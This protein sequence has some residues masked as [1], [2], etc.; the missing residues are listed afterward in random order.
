ML[1][2][3]DLDDTLVT[4]DSKIP[5]EICDAIILARQ[6][7][8]RIAVLTGRTEASAKQFLNLLN[9]NA[10]YSTSHG[11]RIVG[12]DGTLLRETNLEALIVRQLLSLC[13]DIPNLK[14]FCPTHDRFY[15]HDV[16]DEFGEWARPIYN[17][18]NCFTTYSD[19]PVEKV[20]FQCEHGAAKIF[21]ELS[22]AYPQLSY[23]PWDN[24]LLE[25]TAEGAKKGLALA[26][27]AESM[28]IDQKETIAFGDGVNDVTMLA[29]AGYGVAVGN[30]HPDVLAVAKERIDKPEAFGVASWIR[31]NLL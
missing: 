21:S 25:I 17:E 9:V 27:I 31:N 5:E 20:V 11:A 24:G 19:E 16:D 6:A 26:L 23:Y 2:A 14:Y 10:C 22:N 7:G 8:H 4:Q 28:G 3:F 18:I 15:V 30:A 1:L 13:N 12:P 29:W